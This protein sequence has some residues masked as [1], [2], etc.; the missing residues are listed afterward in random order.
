MSVKYSKVFKVHDD[1]DARIREKEKT[2]R[3]MNSIIGEILETDIEKFAYAN[4]PKD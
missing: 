1:E 2:E 4:I 3:I